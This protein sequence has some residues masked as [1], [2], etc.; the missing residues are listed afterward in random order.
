M[1]TRSNCQMF[2]LTGIPSNGPNTNAFR[3]HTQTSQ[4]TITCNDC[5]VIVPCLTQG[6]VHPFSTILSTGKKYRVIYV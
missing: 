5:G 6:N 4:H 3:G 2:S 1:N